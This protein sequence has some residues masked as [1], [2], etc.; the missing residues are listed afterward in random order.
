MKAKE[1]VTEISSRRSLIGGRGQDIYPMA[2]PLLRVQLMLTRNNQKRLTNVQSSANFLLQTPLNMKFFDITMIA[3][4]T[5][6]AIAAN[7]LNNLPA[8]A[9]GKAFG[10]TNC[11]CPNQHEQCD[12]WH[13]PA[14]DSTNQNTV[15]VCGQDHTGCVWI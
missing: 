12:V 10:K 15:M 14:A 11:R 3:C 4:L 1:Q 8:C 9:N 6:G 2:V 5:A 7:C 13:C